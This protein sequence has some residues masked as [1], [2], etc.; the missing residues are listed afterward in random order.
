MKFLHALKDFLLSIVKV[1][2]IIIWLILCIPFALWIIVGIMV[3][4]IP[5][6]K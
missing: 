1:V 2:L 4:V 3:G 6:N 5:L